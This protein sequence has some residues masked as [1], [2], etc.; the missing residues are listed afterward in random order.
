MV[1]Q[2]ALVEVDITGRIYIL[3]ARSTIA[4]L[5]G[6]QVFIRIVFVSKINLDADFLRQQL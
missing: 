6:S 1:G 5:V 4:A 2:A 3:A